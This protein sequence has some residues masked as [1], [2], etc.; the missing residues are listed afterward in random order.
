MKN[1]WKCWWLKYFDWNR[2]GYTNWWEY[3]IPFLAVV[4]IEIIA[5]IIVRWI[6]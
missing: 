5:E 4:L 6:Y 3:C 2:D 1:G